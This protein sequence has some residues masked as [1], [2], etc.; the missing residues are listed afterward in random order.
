MKIEL[1]VSVQRICNIVALWFATLVNYSE[2][3]LFAF[4]CSGSS[5]PLDGI[6][7]RQIRILDTN[8]ETEDPSDT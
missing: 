5:I 7:E 6:V 8:I 1:Q 4:S 3:F 2:L